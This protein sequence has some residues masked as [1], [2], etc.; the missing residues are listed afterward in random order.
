MLAKQI[1]N[2][3]C[4]GISGLTNLTKLVNGRDLLKDDIY[5]QKG[6]THQRVPRVVLCIG[7]FRNVDTFLKTFVEYKARQYITIE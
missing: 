7:L 4:K 6:N 1:T 3:K 2:Q 5:F